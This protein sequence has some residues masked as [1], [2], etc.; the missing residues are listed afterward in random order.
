MH[1]KISSA[2]WRT[3]CPGG[4]ELNKPVFLIQTHTL[5]TTLAPTWIPPQKKQK[6]NKKKKKK[7]KTFYEQWRQIP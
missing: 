7:K 4:D 5:T 1:F 3:F 6:K 2:K